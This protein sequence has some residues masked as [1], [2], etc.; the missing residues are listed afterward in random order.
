MR[1]RLLGLSLLVGLIDRF[2][3]KNGNSV[4][5]C[6]L[7]S[8]AQTR[9]ESEPIT[10]YKRAAGFR[11]FKTPL[12]LKRQHSVCDTTLLLDQFLT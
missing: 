8:N 9:G 1:S 6:Q 5:V 7:L 11:C 10:C 2:A 12:M 3:T 4:S